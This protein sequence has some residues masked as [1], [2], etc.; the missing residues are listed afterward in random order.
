MTDTLAELSADAIDSSAG[1]ILAAI[2]E[3][4]EFILGTGGEIIVDIAEGMTSLVGGATNLLFRQ[5]TYGR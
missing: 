1:T 4:G 5:W 2:K 3:I